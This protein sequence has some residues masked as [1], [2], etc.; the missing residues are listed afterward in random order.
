MGEADV[1]VSELLKVPTHK[2]QDIRT[3]DIR[4]QA[5]RCMDCHRLRSPPTKGRPNCAC[6]SIRFVSTFPHPDEE[7][8]ALK[9]YASEIEAKNLYDKIAQEVVHGWN[10]KDFQ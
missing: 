10:N 8:L 3:K 4:V 7:Q 6:G 1:T 2:G 9:L 5:I